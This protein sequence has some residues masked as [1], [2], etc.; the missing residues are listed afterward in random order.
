MEML[1]IML[2]VLHQHWH[3]FVMYAALRAVLAALRVSGC[4]SR[5]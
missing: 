1:F 5:A 3:L 4:L 2:L